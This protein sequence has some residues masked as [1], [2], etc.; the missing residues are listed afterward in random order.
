MDKFF[1]NK[2]KKLNI[3]KWSYMVKYYIVNIYIR[4]G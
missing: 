2:S 3:K 4:E 1:I